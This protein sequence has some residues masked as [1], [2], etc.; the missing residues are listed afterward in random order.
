MRTVLTQ[1]GKAK[2]RSS[3]AGGV[4]GGFGIFLRFVG[5]Y[6]QRTISRTRPN[7]G[8]QNPFARSETTSTVYRY[9]LFKFF[10]NRLKNSKKSMQHHHSPSLIALSTRAIDTASRHGT[11]LASARV[12]YFDGAGHLRRRQQD[13]HDLCQKP[14]KHTR[15][16]KEA[17]RK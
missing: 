8:H 14:R 17:S 4:S 6:R 10:K 9:A 11:P 12:G 16:K 3:G 13:P 7:P 5:K 2:E 15:K 1:R